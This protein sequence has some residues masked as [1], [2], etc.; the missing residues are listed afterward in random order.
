M[1]AKEATE[2]AGGVVIE[3]G[4]R[5]AFATCSYRAVR[6]KCHCGAEKIMSLVNIRKGRSARCH[7]CAIK[8]NHK[9][10]AMNVT[11]G[12]TGTPLY[13]VWCNMRSR[14]GK[15]DYLD[16]TVC[17][18]W[19]DFV[20]FQSWALANGYIEGLCMHRND[21]NG[22]Y[23]PS[24]CEFM[25]RKDHAALHNINQDRRIRQSELK[26]LRSRRT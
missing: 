11:H 8:K 25:S 23:S 26:K 17:R 21:N 10:Y 14:C 6:V 15:G 19:A 9:D 1:G 20:T 7:S 16:T 13:N 18:E 4:L 2:V 12:A 24:N 5:I 3:T 22:P